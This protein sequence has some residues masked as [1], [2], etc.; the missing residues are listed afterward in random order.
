MSVL[1]AKT[2]LHEFVVQENE[3]V[4]EGL[5]R[6]RC[7]TPL[8]AQLAPGQFVQVGVPAD[9]SH[10]LRIPLSFARA[11]ARTEELDIVYAVVGEG[12][13]RLSNMTSGASS[14]MVGPCGNG[15]HLPQLEGRAL[16]VAGGVGLPPVVA[17]ASMLARAGVGFDV[18]VGAQTAT[19]H[20]LGYIDELRSIGIAQGC[21]C[22]RK[23]IL[24]TDDGTMGIRGFVTQAMEN[25]LAEH[26]YAQVYTCGPNVMMAGV[27]RL[28]EGSA[29]AC[30]VSLE[31]MMGCGFGACSCCNVAL[32]DGTQALCCTDG[33]V[34]DARRVLWQA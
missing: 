9:G 25:L 4:A 32:V 7:T 22:A 1:G 21:D 29:T 18:V 14:T 15:W 20:C 8:A 10:I 24:T 3:P 2:S 16:L 5:W 17:C 11:D 19:R 13:R 33:P 23:V 34:F 6:M 27:A 28:A 30:Q 31:R 12:T 26:T